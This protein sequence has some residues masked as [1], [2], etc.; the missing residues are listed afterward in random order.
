M[1]EDPITSKIRL[2]LNALDHD[3]LTGPPDGLRALA[4]EFCIPA[5]AECIAEVRRLDPSLTIH[6]GS[7][8][9]IR[10]GEDEALCVGSTHQKDH[11]KV[12]ER[13]AALPYVRVI[14]P[15]RGE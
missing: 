9:G 15:W 6:L 11:R 13:L 2:D 14:V 8:G 5:R 7:P 3:G 10:C 1:D 4:Y 12:L